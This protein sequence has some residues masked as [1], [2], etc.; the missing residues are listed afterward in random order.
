M[1]PSIFY[2]WTDQGVWKPL[3]RFAPECEE[4]FSV[5]EVHQLEVVQPR[6]K[7][8]HDHYFVCLHEAYLQL[9]HLFDREFTNE[10]KFR[11][12]LLIEAGYCHETR[13][14]AATN[15]DAE[16]FAALCA[17]LDEYARVDV[18]GSFVSVRKARSQ[19]KKKM[20]NRV[21]QESK[22]AVFD[23]Y[24]KLTGID[25]TTLKRNAGRA[26]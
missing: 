9:P 25:P 13:F 3:P 2:T 8:S 4:H 14:Q 12:W 17:G 20:G 19:S 26:A 21:F 7:E 22:Q 18:L 6:S 15:E 1:K 16:R 5:G 24:Y 11:K 10:T 23:V